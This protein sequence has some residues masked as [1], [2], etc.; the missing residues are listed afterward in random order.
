LLH[1]PAHLIR[2]G[3]PGYVGVFHSV[4]AVRYPRAARVICRTWRGLEVGQVLQP[5]EHAAAAKDGSVL[6]RVTLEDDLLL[7]RLQRHRDDAFRECCRLLAERGIDAVLVDVEQLF[8]GTSLYFYFLGEDPPQLDRLTGELAQRY[9]AQVEFHR[10][11]E[12]LEQGCGPGCGTESAAGA[13]SG[14]SCSSCAVAAACR[15]A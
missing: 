6:R 10:F 15:Q 4:D 2:F 13:C 14:G 11:A 9:A 7:A 1:L 12:T 5:I 3:L 8:D